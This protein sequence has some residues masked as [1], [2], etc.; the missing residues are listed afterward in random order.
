MAIYRPVRADYAQA[1]KSSILG[2]CPFKVA[3]MLMFA[4]AG[5]MRIVDALV[6]A[7]TSVVKLCRWWLGLTLICLKV[8]DIF[9]DAHV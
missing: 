7:S 3:S 1:R 5:S 4:E 2:G 6:L 9:Q 8:N